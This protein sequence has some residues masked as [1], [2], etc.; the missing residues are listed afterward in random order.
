MTSSHARGSAG[1][2]KVKLATVSE[3]PWSLSLLREFEGLALRDTV[4]QHA[5]DSDPEIADLILFVDAHQNLSDWSM[6]SL[7]RHPLVQRFPERVLVY[8]E[9]D[10]PV[11]LF[12]G[13]Y[14]SMPAKRFDPGRHRAFAYYHLKTE[15]EDL[16][17]REPDLLFSFQGRHVA[18]FRDDIL[19]L[20]HPR[21]LVEETSSY[22]FF[23]GSADSLSEAR[24][25][26]RDVVGRS[27]FVLCPRGAGTSTFRLFEVLAAGRV[28]VIVSDDWVAPEGVQWSK[29]SVRVREND[30]AAI[31]RVL[32]ALETDWPIMSR[33]A[34]AA[35]LE[36]FSLDVWF[37]N[38]V[39]HCRSIQM[40]GPPGRRPRF[41]LQSALWRL[42]A[43]NGRSLL[44]SATARR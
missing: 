15:T 32:A 6:H 44:R 30:V 29:V 1:S 3:A 12:P 26:Y 28:P 42:G 43:R 24:S 22:D 13:V 4:R 23:R 16:A 19:R 17:D 8:D 25:R 33:G 11:D 35:Y 14:V 20:R 37:H 41:W 34:R 36:R 7:R 40:N 31:P 9:R 21:A 18:G 38:L 2:L 39:E 5:L 27:K 10:Q